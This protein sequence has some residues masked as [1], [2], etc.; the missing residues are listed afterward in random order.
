LEGL[1]EEDLPGGS[2]EGEEADEDRAGDHG[3][4]EHE[5]PAVTVREAAPDRGEYGEGQGG[6][7]VD[8]A[9]PPVEADGVAD[10]ELLEE[11]GDDRIGCTEA[12]D[13]QE[14]RNPEDGEGLFPGSHAALSYPRAGWK[15][16]T[17]RL[18]HRASRAPDPRTGAVPNKLRGTSR[19]SINN[20][21]NMKYQWFPLVDLRAW[22]LE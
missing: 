4:E 13:G 22:T 18:G 12:G 20:Y 15:G 9:C 19:V 1:E 7:G 11:K 6:D 8:R 21:N 16:N 2:R 5:L 17:K 10:A 3:P 14:F